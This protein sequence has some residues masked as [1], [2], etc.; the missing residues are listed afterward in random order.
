M[1]GGLGEIFAPGRRHTEEERRRQEITLDEVG[2]SDPGR[3]PIDL[4]SGSVVIRVSPSPSGGAGSIHEDAVAPDG[5]GPVGP[6]GPTSPADP[7]GPAGHDGPGPD[8]HAPAGR[9]DPGAPDDHD[10][11]R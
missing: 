10:G 8:P 2:D 9:D 3:G 6:V 7:G 4:A 11:G 1:F 5:D